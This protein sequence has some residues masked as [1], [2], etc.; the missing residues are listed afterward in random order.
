[1]VST[2]KCEGGHWLAVDERLS[3]TVVRC[4]V[5]K[6]LVCVPPMA[7][8]VA[9]SGVIPRP[10][11]EQRSAVVHTPPGVHR[12]DSPW[13]NAPPPVAA[14]SR[15]VSSESTVELTPSVVFT[16]QQKRQPVV[17]RPG[18]PNRVESPRN[19][20]CE[21]IGSAPPAEGYSK[22]PVANLLPEA[23]R[24]L[25]VA[26]PRV[27]ATQAEP[28]VLAVV[29]SDE[30]VIT[31][32]AV[33]TKAEASGV[34]SSSATAGVPIPFGEPSQPLPLIAGD[35]RLRRRRLMAR[36]SVGRRASPTIIVPPD[37]YQAEQRW[38]TLVKYL[39]IGLGAA[40]LFS[41]L[42]VLTRGFLNLA[43]APT[44]A[45][46]V[47]LVSALQATYV[48]WLMTAPD[49]AALRVMMYVFAAAAAL[50]ALAGALALT[51][52]AERLAWL[53]MDEIQHAARSWCGAAMAVMMLASYVCGR[54]AAR[55]RSACRQQLT[56]RHRTA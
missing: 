44:W 4:G 22:L 50:Y 49:W 36:R 17:P 35:G 45:R 41:L 32:E 14:A 11:P 40:I 43:T 38:I 54:F 6:R 28:A 10:R 16:P 25:P 56:A 30:P 12:D 19:E 9:E 52:P 42:P 46:V 47:L 27:A 7:I 20:I 33:A 2:V 29:L 1:M 34:A 18:H 39:S 26:P 24:S 8:L 31:P 23:G 13:S 55:W 48:L 51:A 53:G 37:A 5:C 15:S 21:A 3:G